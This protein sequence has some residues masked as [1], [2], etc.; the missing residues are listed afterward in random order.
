MTEKS[1]NKIRINLTVPS[2]V[3]WN[4]KRFLIKLIIISSVSI[5]EK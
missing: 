4:L 3:R 5:I 2:A 1:E